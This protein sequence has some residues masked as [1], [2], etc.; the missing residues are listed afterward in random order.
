MSESRKAST[1]PRL[2]V[3]C[4]GCVCHLLRTDTARQQDAKGLSKKSVR[5]ALGNQKVYGSHDGQGQVDGVMGMRRQSSL[6]SGEAAA[7]STAAGHESLG[8][9][10]GS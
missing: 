10:G 2:F 5:V 9:Q 3:L 7:I 1:I 4:A 8:S 6:I